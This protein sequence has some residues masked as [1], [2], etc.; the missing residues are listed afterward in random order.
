[1]Q[2][3]QFHLKCI[4]TLCGKKNVQ[5]RNKSFLPCLLFLPNFVKE[6]ATF[7]LRNHLTFLEIIRFC[8]KRK[9]AKFLQKLSFYN[10][11]PKLLPQAMKQDCELDWSLQQGWLLKLLFFHRGNGHYKIFR[12]SVM[13]ICIGLSSKII[14]F[15]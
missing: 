12:F 10:E 8:L 11:L 13:W 5:D 7:F 4:G 9:T 6:K 3:L 1:M 15:C 14:N 2:L